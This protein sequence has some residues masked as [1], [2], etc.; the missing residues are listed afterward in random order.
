ME[1]ALQIDWSFLDRIGENPFLAMWFLFINGGWI[2][3]LVLMISSALQYWQGYKQGVFTAKKQ[4]V[5][6]AIDVP[7]LQEQGPRAIENMFAYL[8]GA[9]SSNTWTEDWFVGRT[10]DT[11]SC[12]IISI[13]GHVQFV[14]RTTKSMR[15]LVESA[16][17]S[18]YPDAEITQI[19]DYSRNVPSHY[20]DKEWDVWGTEMIP[21]KSDVYPLKT[22]PYFEDKI[23]MAFKDPISAM[24][25]SM[26][27]LGPGEQVWIQYVLL[28]IGQG[29][30][31]KKA[32]AAIKKLK[33]EKTEHKKSIVDHTLDLPLK[34]MGLIAETLIGG[35]PAA[36]AKKEAAGPAK[37]S[38]MTQGER[39]VI[40]AIELKAS[41]IVFKVK[42]RFIYAAKKAVMSKPRAVYPFIGAIKQFN[43]NHLLSLKPETK[44]VGVSGAL[45]FFKQSRNAE[46]KHHLITAYRNRSTWMG[47]HQF[48]LNVEELATL[49][50]FPQTLQS[51][52]PQLKKTEAKRAEPPSNLPFA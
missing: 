14:I 28:P 11:I 43:T 13:E 22:Y 36:P 23:A 33:G 47:E 31:V 24:L 19:E 4:W 51:K 10:Q 2:I 49:W 29:D 5:V 44:R 37:I 21:T 12:E 6:L 17:Y 25:E 30:F 46:R 7:K 3:F 1:E 41:K 26:S 8:A 35:A 39:D 52:T 15:D 34:G 48:H 45:W 32:E 16:I 27:R 9:H 50:H 40:T 42:V 18:Q 38:T 20:P